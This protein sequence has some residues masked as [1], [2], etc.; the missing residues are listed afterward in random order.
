LPSVADVTFRPCSIRSLAL[1][2]ALIVAVQ[3]AAPAIAH[4]ATGSTLTL[5]ATPATAK[6]GDAIDLSGLLSFAD[7]SPSGDQTIALT[8]DD[9]TGSHPLPDAVTADDGTYAATDVVG[10]GG[11]VTYHAS[12]AGTA[13]FDPADASDTV[14]VTKF[15]SNISL[16]VSARTVTF[17]T[18]VHLTAHLGKGTESRVVAIY[19]APDGGSEALIRRAKVDRHRDLRATFTPS[20]DTTFIARYEGDPAHRASHDD[21]LTRVRAIVRATLSKFVARSGRYHI[22][23]KGAQ[24]PCFVRVL[25]NHKGF[26]VRATLQVFTSGHW[27]KAARRSFR[28]N[29]SSVV[30]FAIR[31]SSNAN[32]RVH[33]SLP[34]HS[35]HLG[36][37]SPWQYLRFR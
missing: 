30:G 7:M 24:A 10:V 25:P 9:A 28:L 19:A 3:L 6:V 1:A 11:L 33:V 8:R 27:R 5:D 4:A 20:K 15:A 23:R 22:Y 31:G 26:A 35:D 18:A 16:T 36:D 2:C 32:F 14:S 13:G 17:G 37:T 21:V 34:T 29:G 12:F